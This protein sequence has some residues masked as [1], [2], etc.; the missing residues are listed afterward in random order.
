VPSLERHGHSYVLQVPV[1]GIP[2]TFVCAQPL[3]SVTSISLPSH[4]SHYGAP[5]AKG[6]LAGDRIVCPWHAACFNAC[7]GDIEDGPVL[8]GLASYGTKVDEATGLISVE[9]PQGTEAIPRSVAPSMCA[10]NPRSDPRR[11]VVIGAG[12]ASAAAIEALRHNGF[13]GQITLLSKENDL[14]Y[15]RPKLSKQMEITAPEIMLRK[16]GWYESL[17]IE[18]KTGAAGTVTQVKPSTK[19]VITADGGA[20]SY[21]KLLCASGGVP[22]RFLAPEKF[23]TPGAQLKN[24]FPL[25]EIAHAV[26]IESAIAANG[27]ENCPVVI[28]GSSFIGME[29]AAYLRGMKKL[30]KVTVLGMESVP[31]ERVLGKEVGSYM[32]KV[33][34]AKGVDFRLGNKAVV[35]SFNPSLKDHDSVGSVTLA[36]GEEIV[37]SVVIIGAGIIPSTEYLANSDCKDNG[38]EVAA[39]APGGVKVDGHLCTGNPDIFAA[40][41][42]AYFPFNPKGSAPGAHGSGATQM[43]TRIEHWDVAHDQGR[44][45]ARNMLGQEVAYDCVP[46]F[47]T[48][49]YGK[50]LRYA[51][52][53]HKYDKTIVH[54]S[55]EVNA[56]DG[57]GGAFTIFYVAGDSVV[58]VATMDKD[59]QAVAAME[60]LRLGLMPSPAL[61]AA[62]EDFDLNAYLKAKTTEE[63]AAGGAGAGGASGVA[64]P[65][66]T[67]GVS[68]RTTRSTA[69]SS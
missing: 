44:V 48:Q 60:L 17:G 22:R 63:A 32:E 40:G 35:S 65:V 33:H 24:I 14:A 53:C 52:H 15:D 42:L 43:Y 67:S 51:G 2:V 56:A 61:L 64:A 3:C 10:A 34:R 6:V 47:W 11:F 69:A 8:D 19:Q 45:A 54:G 46:F 58:A 25:R 4:C 59:P 18:I 16:P 21:D 31:F 50:S 1:S 66:S 23:T 62:R 30:N 20:I 38:V 39:V 49:S 37:A 29:A 7:S 57:K 13:Q 5:L 41:D 68:R 28:V 12:A 27:G 36:S 55:L 9:L 26:D